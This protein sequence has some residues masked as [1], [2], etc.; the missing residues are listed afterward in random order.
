MSKVFT[1][2]SPIDAQEIWQGKEASHEEIHQAINSARKAFPAWARLK[3]EQRLGYLEKF[4]EIVE[5]QKEELALAISRDVGK[6]LW[7]ARTEVA[8]LP[9]KFKISIEAY[10]DRCKKRKIQ[11]GNSPDIQSVTRHKPHGVL[12]VFGP[13]NFPMHT[14]NG[15]IMPALIAGNTL[16]FKPSELTPYASEL[17]FKC[18]QQAGLP[19]GVINLVQGKAEV[20]KYLSNHEDINGILFTGSSRTGKLL[21]KQFAGNTSKILAVEMGGNNPLIV[22]QVS[23][24]EAAAYNTIQSAFITSGQ[25]CTCA[26]RLILIEGKESKEF[27]DALVAMSE[28][29]KIGNPIED[30]VF[31]G[32]VISEE[33]AS[34]VYSSYKDL[35]AHGGKSLLEAKILDDQA[36]KAYIS[37]SIVDV[38]DI[39]NLDDEEVF[40]PLLQVFMVKD[41]DQAIERANATKYGL[42]SGLFSDDAKLFEDFFFRIKA[43]LAN[44]NNQ[45]TGASSAAPFGGIGDSGNHRP[46][47]YYAADYCAYPV[48]SIESTTLKLPEKLSPGWRF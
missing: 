5:N 35:V 15:H 17:M 24:I 11:F 23:D 46:S 31:M 2:I 33:Q 39:K 20:G 10:Q 29:I 7:E 36:S 19:E 47:A 12:A 27:L 38:S 41:W 32:P 6:P 30:E 13:Y 42:S 8:S 48:A 4:V 44:W 3:V 1:S 40:G 34:L 14:P 26:R 28:K 21:H 9:N 37:P 45:I 43:G 22:H 18:W 16:V 25:R